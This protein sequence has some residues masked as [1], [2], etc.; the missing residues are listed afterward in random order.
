M[1]NIAIH[2]QI[3]VK[4]VFVKLNFQKTEGK[5]LVKKKKGKKLDIQSSVLLIYNQLYYRSAIFHR[6]ELE[7]HYDCLIVKAHSLLSRSCNNSWQV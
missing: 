6:H 1:L 4:I 5:K 7:T 3:T 2:M